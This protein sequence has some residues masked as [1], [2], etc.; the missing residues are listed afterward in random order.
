VQHVPLDDLEL[1]NQCRTGDQAAFKELVERYQRKVYQIAFGLVRNRED[2]LDITQEAFIRVHRYLEN[3]KG[4]SS[5]YTWVYRIVVNLCIDHLRKDEKMQTL[6]Y[7]D[8]LEHAGAP[9]QELQP[10]QAETLPGEVLDRKELRGQIR[11]ALEAL[12]P[13]HRAII[14]M[15]EVEDLSYSEMAEIMNCSKG[16]IMSRLFHA[17]RRLQQALLTTMEGGSRGKA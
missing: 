8:S 11:Q 10:S 3:F 6:D 13:T 5:F 12:S 14:I 17:R 4:S 9:E 1:V 15:R 7:D 16:T 2:A